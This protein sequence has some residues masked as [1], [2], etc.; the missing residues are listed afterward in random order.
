MVTP[1]KFK[2]RYL[3]LPVKRKNGTVQ[4]VR[5]GKYRLNGSNVDAELLKAYRNNVGRGADDITIFTEYGEV[6]ISGDLRKQE[7]RLQKKT[8]IK[9]IHLSMERDGHLVAASSTAVD[10]G[11]SYAL[12]G[13]GSPEHCQ[14]VLQLAERWNLA[15]DGLQDYADKA[16]GLDCNG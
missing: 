1:S 5:V 14:V 12:L 11:G 10:L 6:K 13:K 3:N 8:H 7:L 9:D 16:L 4:T 15:K 2:E